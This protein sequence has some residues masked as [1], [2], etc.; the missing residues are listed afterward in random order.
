MNHLTKVV[1]VQQHYLHQSYFMTHVWHSIKIMRNSRPGAV[2]DSA[3]KMAQNFKNLFQFISFQ[4]LFHLFQIHLFE[5]LV[6]KSQVFIYH[7]YTCTGLFYALGYRSK[8][9]HCKNRELTRCDSFMLY[10]WLNK[11]QSTQRMQRPSLLAYLF[12]LLLPPDIFLRVP[13]YFTEA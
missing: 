1:F 5:F 8:T 7:D 10:Q 13:Y 12:L 3:P 9:I 2:P 4:I 11:I 6:R